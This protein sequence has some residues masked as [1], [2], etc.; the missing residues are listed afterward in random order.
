MKISLMRCGYSQR[1]FFV[2]YDNRKYY[3]LDIAISK[4]F[5]LSVEQYR[6][7]LLNTGIPCETD[8]S[9]EVYLKQ[10]LT[11]EQMIELFKKEFSTE[12]N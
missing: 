6:E 11:N 3:E 5:G 8:K 9:G 1:V 10:T 4:Y 7:R 2:I 12:W